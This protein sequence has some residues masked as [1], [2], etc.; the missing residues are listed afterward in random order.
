MSHFVAYFSLEL[1]VR[2]LL[3]REGITLCGAYLS[4]HGSR[5]QTF[6]KN[7]FNGSFQPNEAEF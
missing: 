6:A 4:K 2:G 1:L 7:E 3:H 5:D